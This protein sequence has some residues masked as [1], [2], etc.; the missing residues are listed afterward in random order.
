MKEIQALLKSPRDIIRSVEGLVDEKNDLKKE[1]EGLRDRQALAVK[2]G[3]IQKV[4]QV[5]GANLVISKVD[6]PSAEILKKIA[7]ELKNEVKPII[8]V[9]TSIINGKPQIA[10]II[11][12]GLV[13]SMGL[14]A[15]QIV[16]QLATLIGGGGGGQ[17]FFATAG[18]KNVDGLQQVV[19]EAKKMFSR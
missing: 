1:L 5:N 13:K 17:A 9:L 15:G 7:F 10:V 12:E 3:L 14:N 6:V 2:E 11:D 18:G 16:R 19:D 4:E 8:A